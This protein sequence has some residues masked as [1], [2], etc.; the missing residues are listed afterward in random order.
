ML[1]SYGTTERHIQSPFKHEQLFTHLSLPHFRIFFKKLLYCFFF[2]EK[3][4]LNKQIQVCLNNTA[5]CGNGI[6][7]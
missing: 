5:E 3:L 2:A 6:T 7:D 1:K 4:V